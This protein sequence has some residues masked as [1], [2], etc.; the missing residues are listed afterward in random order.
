[1]MAKKR[2]PK[3]RKGLAAPAGIVGVRCNRGLLARLDGWRKKQEDKPSRSEAIRR[4]VDYALV[5][6]PAGKLPI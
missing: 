2:G 6:A 1:M 3:P 4:L 5:M